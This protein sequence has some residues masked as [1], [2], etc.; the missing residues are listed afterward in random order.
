TGSKAPPPADAPVLLEGRNVEVVFRIGGGFLV[1]D[2][3]LLRAVD[4]ISIRLKRSQ[5]IGI[6]GESGSGK[7]TLGRALLRLL[8]SGG[9]I[10]F[11]DRDISE[12]DRQ[13]MRP[14]RR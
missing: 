10:H 6:V 12:A 8:P 4:R 3:L 7:S 1:R 11:A 13:A 9:A 14:L 5:T 2:P